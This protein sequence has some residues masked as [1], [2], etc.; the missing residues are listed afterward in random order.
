MILVVDDHRD[1]ASFLCK[2]LHRQ[3]YETLCAADGPE[4]LAFLESSTPQLI[5]LDVQMPGMSGLEVLEVMQADARLKSIPVLVYSAAHER[6]QND[7]ALRLGAKAFLV[8]GTVS[9]PE[10]LAFVT[11]HAD[12]PT[13]NN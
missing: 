2:I 8:K 4:A 7:R 11:T 12:S 13:P 3:G 10:L 9:V 6:S 1:T 5:I